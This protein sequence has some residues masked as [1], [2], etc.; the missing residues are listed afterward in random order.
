MNYLFLY[1]SMRKKSV[2]GDI[3]NWIY[4]GLMKTCKDVNVLGIKRVANVTSEDVA[5]ADVVI[6]GSPI[7]M[8][9]PMKS[10][11]SFLEK[12]MENLKLKSIVLFVVCI[13]LSK[14]E[15]YLK[16]LKSCV[17]VSVMVDKVFGGRFLFI[18]RVDKSEAINF[19]IKLC[20][21]RTSEK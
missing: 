10:I 17:N 2:T 1:D 11:L 13:N 9:K 12:N 3:C 5:K 4:E 8:G 7:Y 21:M 18:N 6:I 15:E 16:K 19:G 20:K 14:G